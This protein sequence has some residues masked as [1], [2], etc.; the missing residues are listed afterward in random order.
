LEYRSAATSIKFASPFQ[1]K[2]KAKAAA[3]L[4]LPTS[5]LAT[6][7][8]LLLMRQTLRNYLFQIIFIEI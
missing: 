2:T 6:A 8:A 5:D 3:R 1:A 4:F 7:D